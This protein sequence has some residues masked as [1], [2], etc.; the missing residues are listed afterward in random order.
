[1]PFARRHDVVGLQIAMHYSRGMSFRQS[2]CGVLQITQ[3]LWQISL[4]FVNQMTQREAIAELHGDEVRT[5][6]LTNFIDVRDIRMIKRGCRLRLLDEAAHAVMV[7]S[8][9][10]PQNLSR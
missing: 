6:A 10:S 9:F 1:M 3:K 7:S 4:F 2:I 5:I 8:N